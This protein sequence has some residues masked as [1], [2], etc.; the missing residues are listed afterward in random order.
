MCE[1]NGNKDIPHPLRKSGPVSIFISFDSQQPLQVLLCVLQI[2]GSK[3]PSCFPWINQSDIRQY[4]N[5]DQESFFL[6][7]VGFRSWVDVGWWQQ[8][9]AWQITVCAWK[10]GFKTPHVWVS[11]WLWRG[12]EQSVVAQWGAKRS[13]VVYRLLVSS[14]MAAGPWLPHPLPLTVFFGTALCDV[15]DEMAL[16]LVLFVEFDPR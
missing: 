4:V 11:G 13:R 10:D 14:R 6:L 5:R 16:V 15:E 12:P 9:N 2:I 1:S 3:D 7:L 8:I